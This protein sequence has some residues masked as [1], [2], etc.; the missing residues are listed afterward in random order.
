ME[1]DIRTLNDS[2]YDEI[3]V[4]WWKQWNWEPPKKDFLPE[5]GKG[6]IIVYDGDIPIIAGFIYVTNSKVAWV[7]WIISNKEYRIKEKRAEA[8]KLLIESLTNICKNSGSKYGYA[9]IKNQALIKTYL[10]LGW[11]KGDGYTSEMIKLL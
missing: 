11:S 10:D 8:K 9:L 1:L 4:G 3:L 7:D 2:D 5:D 6:G